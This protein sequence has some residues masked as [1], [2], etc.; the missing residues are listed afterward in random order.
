[1]P[2]IEGNFFGRFLNV[3]SHT[4]DTMPK[5]KERPMSIYPDETVKRAIADISTADHNRPQSHVVELAVKAFAM[6]WRKDRYEAM[7]LADSFDATP[8]RN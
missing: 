2:R 4:G 6:L 1:M 8:A 7:K 3:R 5:A